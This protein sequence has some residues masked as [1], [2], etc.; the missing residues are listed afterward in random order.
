VLKVFV[1]ILGVQGSNI[2]KDLVVI[3]DGMLTKYA[4]NLHK[5]IMWLNLPIQVFGLAK[6]HYT[7]H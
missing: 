5:L 2:T 1:S 3:I 6:V 4:L 7:H